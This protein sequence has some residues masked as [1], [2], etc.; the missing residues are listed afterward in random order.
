MEN[1]HEVIIPEN[2]SQKFYE[3]DQKYLEKTFEE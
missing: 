1:L 3:Y 2:L